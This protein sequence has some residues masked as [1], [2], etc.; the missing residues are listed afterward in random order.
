VHAL[1]MDRQRTNDLAA[2]KTNFLGDSVDGY[3]KSGTY[4]GLKGFNED[5]AKTNPPEY[6]LHAAE[7][8]S[9]APQPWT[10]IKAPDQ[11]Q[12]IINIIPSATKFLAPDGQMRVKP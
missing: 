4:R 6:N 1:Y 11:Q 7:A 10:R 8:M 3:Q 5:F 9:G 2:A 12:A